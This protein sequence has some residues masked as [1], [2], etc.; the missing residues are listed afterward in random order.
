VTAVA[1]APERRDDGAH[2]PVAGFAWG[3]FAVGVCVFAVLAAVAS[4]YGYHRDEL[5]FLEAGRHLSW[6]YPDQPPLVPLLARLLNDLAPGS[7]AVLRVPSAVAVAVVVPV[8][9]AI[10][11]LLG[12]EPAA[13]LLAGGVIA[14][15]AFLVGAGHLLSTATFDFL[16]GC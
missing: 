9:A 3:S 4:R 7:V 1:G 2:A 13:Q 10:A 12:A 8:T 11:R 16:R 15:G 14:V 6:G 5:Y